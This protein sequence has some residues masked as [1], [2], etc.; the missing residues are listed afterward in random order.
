VIIGITEMTAIMMPA[1]IRMSA[2]MRPG[3]SFNGFVYGRD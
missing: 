2:I 3:R 1:G